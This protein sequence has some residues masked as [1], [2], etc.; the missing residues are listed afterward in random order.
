[1]RGIVWPDDSSF[2]PGIDRN[3]AI[4]MVEN[5]HDKGS[6]AVTIGK[7][8]LIADDKNR[9]KLFETFPE[10]FTEQKAKRWTPQLYILKTAKTERWK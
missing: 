4:R 5:L 1:M 8:M 10:Y 2:M 3:T 6:F 9:Q 7:A